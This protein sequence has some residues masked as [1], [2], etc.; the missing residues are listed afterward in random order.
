MEKFKVI[1]DTFDFGILFGMGIGIIFSGCG[2]FLFMDG[3]KL[4]FMQ[5]GFILFVVGVTIMFGSCLTHKADN[6]EKCKDK[7]KKQEIIN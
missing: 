1:R 7:L 4:T 2:T 3:F 6:F 5:Y